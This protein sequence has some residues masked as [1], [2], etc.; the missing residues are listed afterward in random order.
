[1]QNIPL[2]AHGADPVRSSELQ[3]LPAPFG[4]L[5]DNALSVAAPEDI[6]IRAVDGDPDALTALGRSIAAQEGYLIEATVVAIARQ[7]PERLVLAD[8][9]LPIA[10]G[11]LALVNSHDPAQYE[12]LSLAADGRAMQTYHPDLVVVDR[13]RRT[14]LVIDIKRNLGGYGGSGKLAELHA[15]MSAAALSLPDC[16]WR[17]HKR[18]H[19]ERVGV[20]V[21]DASRSETDRAKGLWCLAELD[22]LLEVDG[23]GDVAQRMIAL[24]RTKLRNLWLSHVRHAA[25][26]DQEPSAAKSAVLDKTTPPAPPLPEKRKRGRPKKNLSVPMTVQLFRPGQDPVH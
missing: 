13:A 1:M 8:M 17:D 22:E 10:E 20:A 24:F 3:P 12:T 6:V 25:K 14:G 18:I 4:R 15:R 19:I 23:G 5:I 9:R 21:I 26:T 16:L 2:P 11:A 7:H